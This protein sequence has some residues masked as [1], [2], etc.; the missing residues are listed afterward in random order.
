M[1]YDQRWFRGLDQTRKQ[2]MKDL[3]GNNNTILGKLVEM[4]DEDLRSLE[5]SETSEKALTD[6]NWAIHQAIRVGQKSSL[7]RL[8]K[9]IKGE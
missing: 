7:I 9:L 3:L 4:I 2:E 1:K 5:I 8:R 6:P